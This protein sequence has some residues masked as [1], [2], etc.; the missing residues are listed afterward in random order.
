MSKQIDP[1]EFGRMQADVE[2][3]KADIT[4]IK[5]MTIVFMG[6]AE[7]ANSRLDTMEAVEEQ[8]EKDGARSSKKLGVVYGIIA[9]VFGFVSG[10]FKDW[11]V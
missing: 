5:E 2:H 9:S 1:V 4:Q 8:R 3:I 6:A 11:I 7:E 10:M